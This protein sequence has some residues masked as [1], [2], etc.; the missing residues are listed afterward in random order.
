MRR[1]QVERISPMAIPRLVSA[2]QR[3]EPLVGSERAYFFFKPD[4]HQKLFVVRKMGRK[5]RMISQG[6][7]VQLRLHLWHNLYSRYYYHPVDNSNI[8]NAL[9]TVFCCDGYTYPHLHLHLPLSPCRSTDPPPTIP[10][11]STFVQPQKLCG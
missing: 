6:T 2:C 11:T 3:R 5:G 10:T 4:R 7:Q 1:K 9:L 8:F